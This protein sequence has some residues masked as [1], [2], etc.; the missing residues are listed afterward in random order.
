MEVGAQKESQREL[1]R[2]EEQKKTKKTTHRGKPRQT[3]IKQQR[4][5]LGAGQTNVFKCP[6][7][8]VLRRSGVEV[9]RLL[10]GFVV[11]V[12]RV[13]DILEGHNGDQKGRP[14]MAKIQHGAKHGHL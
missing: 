14:K 2:N 12:F 9:V 3:E 5:T 6:G 13:D 1:P 7:V 10:V 8:Q 11:G 4:K